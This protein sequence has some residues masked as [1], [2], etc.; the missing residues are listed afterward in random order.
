MSTQIADIE[1]NEKGN[2]KYFVERKKFGNIRKSTDTN[3]YAYLRG[4]LS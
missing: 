1:I 4:F 2:S 3:I